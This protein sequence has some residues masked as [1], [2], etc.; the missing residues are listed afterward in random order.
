M[1]CKVIIFAKPMVGA[2][3]GFPDLCKR[4]RV[5]GKKKLKKNRFLVV[6]ITQSNLPLSAESK[7]AKE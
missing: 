2:F 7:Y 5:Q 4:L 6:V 3:S 1:L